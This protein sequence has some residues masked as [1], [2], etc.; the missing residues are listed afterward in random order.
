M[1]GSDGVVDS[2]ISR[3]QDPDSRADEACRS[4]AGLGGATG[5]AWARL[6][7]ARRAPNLGTWNAT[8]DREPG[9]AAWIS[10]DSLGNTIGTDSDILFAR[11]SDA[12]ASWSTPIVLNRNAASDTGEDYG[13][14]LTTDE[15]GNWVA[16][17][18]SDD[19]LDSPLGFDS[20]IFVATATGP[21][22]DLDGLWDAA[23]VNFHL[24]TGG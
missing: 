19:L 3:Q 9:S 5:S 20:E 4:A 11:S 16:A 1:S 7:N 14:Q 21:D 12:G 24:R 2:L 10:D 13:I 18:R 17:W 6:R 22:A 15:V 8:A 23:E